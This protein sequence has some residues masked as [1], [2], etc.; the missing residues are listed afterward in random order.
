MGAMFKDE[1]GKAFVGRFRRLAPEQARFLL[2]LGG[3]KVEKV[4]SESGVEEQKVANGVFVDGEI[5]SFRLRP[6][7]SAVMV[8][9][10]EKRF[11]LYDCLVDESFG[12]GIRMVIAC[13]FRAYTAP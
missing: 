11:G 8:G 2:H 3:E 5:F 7:V 13:V 10:P 1:E 6:I 12:E 4:D 9:Q